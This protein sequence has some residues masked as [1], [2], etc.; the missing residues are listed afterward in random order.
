MATLKQA[1][2]INPNDNQIKSLKIEIKR[3]Q[4]NTKKY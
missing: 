2:H 3:L 4:L 1:S